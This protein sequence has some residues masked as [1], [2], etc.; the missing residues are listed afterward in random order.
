MIDE[1]KL[2]TGQITGGDWRI[3]ESRVVVVDEPLRSWDRQADREQPCIGVIVVG[4]KV[5]CARADVAV[6]EAQRRV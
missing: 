1:G 5:G 4:L 2:S 3:G 6:L